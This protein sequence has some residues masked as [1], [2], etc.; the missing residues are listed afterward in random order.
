MPLPLDL[1]GMKITMALYFLPGGKSTQK[2]GV[3]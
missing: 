1:G 3:S 2:I